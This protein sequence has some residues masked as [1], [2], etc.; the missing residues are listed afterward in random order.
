[1]NDV[2]QMGDEPFGG[3]YKPKDR[4]VDDEL[5]RVGPGTPCGEYL[6]RFWHPIM[7]SERLT[8]GPLPVRVLGED[9][10]LFRDLSGD[11]GL[12][13][14]HCSHRGMSLE[15]GIIANHGIRCAYHGWC[16]SPTGQILETPGESPKSLLKE[17]VFHGAYPVVDYKGLIFAYMGP[18]ALKPPLIEAAG[19]SAM[20][21]GT[22]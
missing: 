12:V 11:V 6:R 3:Y 1:M 4:P 8:D 5:S 17:R 20:F 10:V 7:M 16:F 9:L 15:F 13:H 14:K 18:P 19:F 21:H 2:T 22:V